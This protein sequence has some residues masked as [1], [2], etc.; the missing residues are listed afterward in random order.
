M[1][2]RDCSTVDLPNVLQ[3]MVDGIFSKRIDIIYR[4]KLV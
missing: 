1:S 2:D 4:I 3:L